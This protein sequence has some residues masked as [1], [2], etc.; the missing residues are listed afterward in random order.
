MRKKWPKTAVGGGTTR[1]WQGKR[2]N[3]KT[4]VT[5]NQS[6]PNSP[7]NKHFY[8]LLR[9]YTC[10]CEGVKNARFSENMAHFVSFSCFL[11]FKI[12]PFALSPMNYNFLVSSIIVVIFNITE[13]ATKTQKAYIQVF[14]T[15]NE[16]THFLYWNRK[17][18]NP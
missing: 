18:S 10:A 17:C 16:V 7:K 11:P 12:C 6:T 4:E 2:T 15:F 14:P 8:P 9:T 1:R 3:L 13:K 5:R